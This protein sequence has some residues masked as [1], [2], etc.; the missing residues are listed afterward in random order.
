M[1]RFIEQRT[2]AS[3]KFLVRG[4][5]PDASAVQALSRGECGARH[6]ILFAAGSG[7]GAVIHRKCAA[8][9]THSAK[10]ETHRQEEL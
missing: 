10:K 4:L 2:E 9:R 3:R 8:A 6:P 1:G 7:L 5:C